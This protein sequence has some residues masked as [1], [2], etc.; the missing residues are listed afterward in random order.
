MD[1]LLTLSMILYSIMDRD[2]LSS[3]V[4]KKYKFISY[5]SRIVKHS[6]ITVT[7]R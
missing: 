7:S 2:Q 3:L 1:I 5:L 4:A 6:P